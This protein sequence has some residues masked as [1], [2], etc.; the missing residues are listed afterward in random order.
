MTKISLQ[1]TYLTVNLPYAK[2]HENDRYV[3]KWGDEVTSLRK[4]RELAKMSQS[5]L[6]SKAGVSERSV[7]RWEQGESL[8][9]KNMLKLATALGVTPN[10]LLGVDEKS[11]GA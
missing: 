11:P 10:D 6:A 1:V 8:T 3:T 7:I 2:I 9:M 5:E 4:I